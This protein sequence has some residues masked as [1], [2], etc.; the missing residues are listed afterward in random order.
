MMLVDIQGGERSLLSSILDA[1]KPAASKSI[2]D[3]PSIVRS[4][5]MKSGQEFSEA[6]TKQ[7][8]VCL[9]FHCYCS[10]LHVCVYWVH[11]CV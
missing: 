1:A 7:K 11:I 10:Y 5:W 4:Y 2:Y 3:I 6:N 9:V 8:E